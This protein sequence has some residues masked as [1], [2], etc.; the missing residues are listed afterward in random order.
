MNKR[1]CMY[2]HKHLYV[3]VCV[4]LQSGIGIYKEMQCTINPATVILIDKAAEQE[5]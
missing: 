1:E 4:Y 3:H 2:E 5:V